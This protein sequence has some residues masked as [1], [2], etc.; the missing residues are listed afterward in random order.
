MTWELGEN[1]PKFIIDYYNDKTK[2]GTKLP[3]PKIKYTKKVGNTMIHLLSWDGQ[4]SGDDKW[5]DEDFF[6]YLNENGE[7]VITNSFQKPE[8]QGTS[9]KIDTVLEFSVGPTHVEQLFYLINCMAQKAWPRF[10]GSSSTYL[11][12]LV[13][14]I[15]CWNFYIMM[16]VTWKLFQITQKGL[17]KMI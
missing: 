2:I 13:T 1:I 9:V 8:S 4:D 3:N 15:L 7:F 17:N 10:M 12:D 6:K 5:L 14:G 16:P 11:L